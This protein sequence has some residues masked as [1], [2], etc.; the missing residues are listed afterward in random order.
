MIEPRPRAKALGD[1]A[2]HERA[3]IHVRAGPVEVACERG[4]T[5]CGEGAVLLEPDDGRARARARARTRAPPRWRPPGTRMR[6]DC[7]PP[8][9]TVSAQPVIAPSSVEV[10][11]DYI[12]LGQLLQLRG[13]RRHRRRG[14]D[15]VGTLAVMT[16][17]PKD[18]A[19]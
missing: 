16:G 19:A 10:T 18:A 12:G 4:A 17:S 3:I 13:R 11:G 5:I 14:Q 8:N 15:L 1:H 2:V 7:L 9:A 6:R